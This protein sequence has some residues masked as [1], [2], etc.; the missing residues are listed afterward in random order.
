M[1]MLEWMKISPKVVPEGPIDSS[2]SLLHI[3][4]SWLF[5]AKPLS[6]PTVAYS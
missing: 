2:L 4:A 1:K 6:E 3:M 5:G